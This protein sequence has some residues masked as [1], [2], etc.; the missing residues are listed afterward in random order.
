MSRDYRSDGWAAIGGSAA[1]CLAAVCAAALWPARAGAE[2]LAD[3][4][5][6]AY[7]SNPTLQAQRASLRALDETYVQAQ[8]GF[9]PSATLQAT[10][11]TETNNLSPFQNSPS[12]HFPGQTQ[13]SGATVTITQ[14]IYTGGRVSSQVGA[15]QA[16]I[17]AGREA[18]RQTE[19]SVLQNV[20][21]TYVD[22]RRDQENQAIA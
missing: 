10:V 22:V 12:Q 15:A 20:V 14:P 19:Q 2:T 16:N 17:L 9:R 1:L 3:A 13:T 4:I 5:T 8:A 6:L 18:L 7:Q 21:Q 11:T